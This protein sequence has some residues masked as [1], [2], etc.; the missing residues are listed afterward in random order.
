MLVL[1]ALCV[2][3]NARSST[4]PAKSY[5]RISICMLAFLRARNAKGLKDERDGWNEQTRRPDPVP[6][7]PNDQNK[8]MA[9]LTSART[10]TFKSWAVKNPWS[11]AS[12]VSSSRRLGASSYFLRGVLWIVGLCSAKRGPPRSTLRPD[13][14]IHTLLCTHNIHTFRYAFAWSSAP[15]SFVAEGGPAFTVAVPPPPPPAIDNVYV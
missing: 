10:T 8:N 15:S 7:L 14:Y 11:N 2:P 13:T 12:A 3:A 5:R 4:S 9:S 1:G 6:P